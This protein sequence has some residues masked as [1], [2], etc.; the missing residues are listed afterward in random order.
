LQIGIQLPDALFF[1]VGLQLQLCLTSLDDFELFVKSV[2]TPLQLLGSVS[3]FC[4]LVM[5]LRDFG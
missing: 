3:E 4:G 1:P 2:R 5:K